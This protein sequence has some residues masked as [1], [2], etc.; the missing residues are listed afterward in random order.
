MDEIGAA[1]A[2]ASGPGGGVGVIDVHIR[3]RHGAVVG[4]GCNL[5]AWQGGCKFISL[6]Y[7][8][9]W[10][11]SL[12]HILFSKTFKLLVHYNLEVKLR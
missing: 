1:A 8:L 4:V 10:V 3:S 6:V 5:I 12:N 9:S 11:F 7:S 2:A